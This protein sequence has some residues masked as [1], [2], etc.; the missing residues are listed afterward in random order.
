V[1]IKA[2]LGIRW[3]SVVVIAGFVASTAAAAQDPGLLPAYRNRL[4]GV[5]DLASGEAVAGAAVTEVKSGTV[6]LTTK[7]GTVTLIFGPEGISTI[8]IRKVGYEPITQQVTIG[9]ADTVPITIMLKSL[10]NTLPAVVTKDSAVH[11]ISPGLREFEERRKTGPGHFVHEADLRKYETWRMK[12]VIAR[13]PGMEVLCSKTAP[14]ACYAASFRAKSK[15]AI[16]G[17]GPCY[18][19]IFIDGMVSSEKDLNSFNVADYAGIELYAGG[20]TIPLKYNQTSNGCGVLL[21]WTR[22]R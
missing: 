12:D 15:Y 1:K 16:L 20:S 2:T 8:Q 6:A 21:F 9:P 17:G 14:F 5:Y 11:Y 4:L 18:Y 3:C 19:T 10:V 22:E 7:T 13:L